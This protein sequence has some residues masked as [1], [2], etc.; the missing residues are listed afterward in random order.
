MCAGLV[1]PLLPFSH[2][3][4]VLCLSDTERFRLITGLLA[5]SLVMTVLDKEEIR[6]YLYKIGVAF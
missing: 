3:R 4:A 5:V 1:C 6:V 2:L